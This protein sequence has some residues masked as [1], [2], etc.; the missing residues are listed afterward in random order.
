MADVGQTGRIDILVEPELQNEMVVL[1]PGHPIM[2][3][4][5]KAFNECL[6]NR[7]KKISLEVKELTTGLQKLMKE[8]T[9]LG[10]NL[11]NLQDDL[12]RNQIKLDVD[13]SK[14]N[15]WKD[16]SVSLN[17]WI[18]ENREIQRTLEQ[19]LKDE[20]KKINQLQSERDDLQSKFRY[21]SGLEKELK[22]DI[23]VMKNVN[24]NFENQLV[25]MQKTKQE[26]DSYAVKLTD[27]VDS[28]QK[29]NELLEN[30]LAFQTGEYQK[31]KLLVAE[32]KMELEAVQL[33][34]RQLTQNWNSCL[35]GVRHRDEALKK[36]ND[37][38]EAQN[39]AVEKAN[40]EQIKI[41][42]QIVD[43]Q[44]ENERL[45]IKMNQT[46]A[47]NNNVEKLLDNQN[48]KLQTAKLELSEINKITIEFEHNLIKTTTEKRGLQTQL[49]S[50]QKEISGMQQ[51]RMRMEEEIVDNLRQRTTLNKTALFSY[52]EREGLLKITKE[53]EAK[54]VA[55]ENHISKDTL[56]LV[57]LD[58]LISQLKTEQET[59][60]KEINEKNASINYSEMEIRRRTNMI[61]HKQA[62]IDY[63]NRQIDSLTEKT[64]LSD[65]GP[66]E[67][68]ILHLQK[69]ATQIQQDTILVEQQW[70]RQQNE[71]V[72]LNDKQNEQ[73]EQNQKYS[74][75]EFILMTRQQRNE[76]KFE[77]V[78]RE[79]DQIE[80]TIEKLRGKLL[81]INQLI[82]EQSSTNK[83]LQNANVRLETNFVMQLR[84]AEKESIKLQNMINE[85]DEEKNQLRDDL[86]T[87]EK[88]ILLWEK[89]I[90]LAK[91]M[92]AS[93]DTDMEEGDMREMK[94]EIHR[95]QIRYDE[96]IKQ[97]EDLSRKLE[98]AA[99]RQETII[100]RGERQHMKSLDPKSQTKPIKAMTERQ[101]K[102]NEMEIQEEFKVKCNLETQIQ[103]LK[104]IKEQLENKPNEIFQLREKRTQELMELRSEVIP[105]LRNECEQNVHE[106]S[107]K[108]KRKKHLQDILDG[109]YCATVKNGK[110]LDE[111]YEKEMEKLDKL[112]NI[113]NLLC[114]EY[115]NVLGLNS[116][117]TTLQRKVNEVDSTGKSSRNE[118]MRN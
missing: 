88:Q 41:Q 89:K 38:V 65:N 16:E 74:Q 115:P 110:S 70:L 57:K 86:L 58:A 107:M 30:Q 78:Q 47:E 97:Q 90:Q 117:Q 20:W 46:L 114:N 112:G 39:V 18:E 42:K 22:G 63:Y 69:K 94:A 87:S 55:A 1:D 7:D 64:G 105:R 99:I 98:Q 45:T 80:K 100:Q 76:E 84:E 82:R 81:K 56:E 93:V 26:Q 104:P 111:E 12:R 109:K 51:E 40:N 59:I 48:E 61:A 29:K 118:S 19:K 6:I 85:L 43:E 62:Q 8:R 113:I 77:F 28:M 15:E 101:I 91:E 71:L 13:K 21:I 92:K 44:R 72:K 79:R 2:Q 36:M 68:E 33:E 75:Q 4:Y 27:Q 35:I 23:N 116:I 24:G 67:L 31:S 106:L 14:A 73:M 96:L 95:M 3:R 54:I 34:I 5:Q 49:S 60:E 52:D 50:A 102:H 11:Y 66:L 103:A 37:A 32:A 17:A 83:D 10:E 108:Q 53:I 25:K 9:D